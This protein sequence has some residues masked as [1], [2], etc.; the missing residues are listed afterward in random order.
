M[1]TVLLSPLNVHL[2]LQVW[3]VLSAV[4][5]YFMFMFLLNVDQDIKFKRRS[6]IAVF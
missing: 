4:A 1:F 5:M 6:Q 3:H 2:D